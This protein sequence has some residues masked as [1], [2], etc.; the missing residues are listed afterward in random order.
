MDEGEM[1]VT[2]MKIF[3]FMLTAQTLSSI[4]VPVLLLKRLSLHIPFH[5]LSVSIHKNLM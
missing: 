1:Y 5:S 3:N 4:S 2:S